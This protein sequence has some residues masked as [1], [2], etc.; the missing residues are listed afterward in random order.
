MNSFALD[1]NARATLMRITLPKPDFAEDTTQMLAN[2]EQRGRRQM[3][4]WILTGC[5]MSFIAGLAV[6]CLVARIAGVM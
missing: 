1:E 5:G 3:R 4:P 2:A 6:A